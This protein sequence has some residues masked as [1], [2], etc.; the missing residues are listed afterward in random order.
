MA[1]EIDTVDCVRVRIDIEGEKDIYLV[2]AKDICYP[3][4]FYE[5]QVET[6]EIARLRKVISEVCEGVTVAL[7]QL[8]QK[9]ERPSKKGKPVKRGEPIWGDLGLGART[10]IN[11]MAL[12]T[13]LDHKYGTLPIDRSGV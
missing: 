6:K 5:N 2:L 4:F 13:K 12:P 8:N 11:D 10:D 7:N 9:K 1:Q 3:K